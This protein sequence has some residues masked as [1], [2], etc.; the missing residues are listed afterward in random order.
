MEAV[1]TALQAII[2]IGNARAGAGGVVY[3][4]ASRE[5][6]AGYILLGVL[7]ILAL[8]VLIVILKKK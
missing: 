6:A 1:A 4:P 8:V 2:G 3:Q 7:G 5:V